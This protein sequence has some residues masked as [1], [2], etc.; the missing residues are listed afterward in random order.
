MVEL[1]CGRLVSEAL[2]DAGRSPRKE[3][4]EDSLGHGLRKVKGKEL[5]DMIHKAFKASD[6]FESGSFVFEADGESNSD[7]EGK[8]SRNVFVTHLR[9]GEDVAGDIGSMGVRLGVASLTDKAE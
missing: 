9:F 6:A 5:I 8:S 1:D 4:R 2:L 7:D 3:P